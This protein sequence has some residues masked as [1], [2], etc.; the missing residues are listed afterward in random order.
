MGA[1]MKRTA[2][3]R[4]RSKLYL[5]VTA[6]LATFSTSLATAQQTAAPDVEEIQITG[7]RV[8]L[9][10]G[11]TAP[12][13]VTAITTDE[14]KDFDPGSTVAAQL[15]DLPQFFDTPNAQ[16]GGKPSAPRAAVPI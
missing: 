12:T 4:S 6:T 10:T 9:Q 1:S 8:R 2:I 14:L 7:S 11:M 15:D 16:R 13:P 5:A 3:S